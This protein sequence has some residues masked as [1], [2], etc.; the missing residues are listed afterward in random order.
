MAMADA[1]A[2]G[3]K[4]KSRKQ[5]KQ[6]PTKNGSATPGPSNGRKGRKR[7]RV[8]GGRRRSG[9]IN[10]ARG[11][12]VAMSQKITATLGTIGANETGGLELE[13]AT[14]FNPALVKEKT[15]SNSFTPLTMLAAQYARWRIAAAKI[16]FTPLVG[17]SAISGTAVRCSVNLS[18]SANPSSWGS[19]GARHHCDVLIG[20][21]REWRIPVRELTG[22]MESFWVTNTNQTDQSL[23]PMLEIHSYGKTMSTYQA[24]AWTGGLFLVSLE[25]T[26]EFAS[27]TQQPALAGLAKHTAENSTVYV[28]AVEGEPVELSMSPQTS[29]FMAERNGVPAL[30]HRGA[31][32][33]G[34][35]T[36]EVIWM[37]IDTAVDV[38]SQFLGPWGWLA[39]AG[40]WF[41]KR[42]FGRTTRA[43][44]DTYYVYASVDDANNNRPIIA[45]TSGTHQI[46]NTHGDLT[47]LQLNSPNIGSYGA[48]S[49]ANYRIAPVP[50]KAPWD[51]NAPF[52][53]IGQAHPALVPVGSEAASPDILYTPTNAVG[54]QVATLGSS[55]SANR[56]LLVPL[57]FAARVVGPAGLQRPL[58]YQNGD[59]Y[60]WINLAPVTGWCGSR[61]LNGNNVSWQPK[62]VWLTYGMV[63]GVG[64][65]VGDWAGTVFLADL[66]SV[67]SGMANDAHD[68]RYLV[69]VT[70]QNH[71]M[72][73]N[74]GSQPNNQVSITNDSGPMLFWSIGK[75]D[76]TNRA[77]SLTWPGRGTVVLAPGPAATQSNDAAMNGSG[78][79]SEM[80]E[81]LCLPPWGSMGIV[82]DGLIQA[83]DAFTV[84][85]PTTASTKGQVPW[86]SDLPPQKE[87][88][89]STRRG[90]ICPVES[91]YV[92]SDRDTE[93]SELSDGDSDYGI[94]YGPTVQGPEPVEEGV[95]PECE[96]CG[97]SIRKACCGTHTCDSL[98]CQDYGCLAKEGT[99][100]E[101]HEALEGLSCLQ[102]KLLFH[103]LRRM[104]YSTV[105]DRWPGW[106]DYYNHVDQLRPK[107]SLAAAFVMAAHHNPP[108]GYCVARQTG[109]AMEG[110]GVTFRQAVKAALAA[111]NSVDQHSETTEL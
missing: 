11:A 104:V 86:E 78:P 65:E 54:K 27:Y 100:P 13:F 111:A 107:H 21:R 40:Y 79:A 56:Q 43:G 103:V 35:N 24:Q 29:R 18:P 51:D 95:S 75:R 72:P 16:V 46:E 8:R 20:Q 101:N 22:P 42:V 88:T 84:E 82:L 10:M 31:R 71:Q 76:S 32:A 66:T 19:I 47:V 48:P 28:Q 61:A 25:A 80:L 59:V 41:V 97:R 102:L 44:G 64:C 109:L 96:D 98:P 99:C 50:E 5:K 39:K 110:T 57:T 81:R 83:T 74:W 69:S 38:A 4:K 37:V 92:P 77:K 34:N 105:P 2:G 7:A 85:G 53:L 58:L 108:P 33:A 63:A 67:S 70:P 26:W 106:K 15:S 91:D 30:G 17:S 68:L 45:N 49:T 12:K 87:K 9:V 89:A 3:K 62:G 90:A 94:Y 93:E 73:T 52:T 6:K 60:D 14:Y 36:S 1:A 55:P 23:G